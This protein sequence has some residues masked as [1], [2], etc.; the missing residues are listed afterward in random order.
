[1]EM[2]QPRGLD[3]ATATMKTQEQGRNQWR[4]TK[5][6]LPLSTNKRSPP[7]PKKAWKKA[8]A[9]TKST[10]K[11]TGK[12][13]STVSTQTTLRRSKSPPSSFLQILM[14]TPRD[15]PGHENMTIMGK[16]MEAMMGIMGEFKSLLETTKN[17]QLP[18][19]DTADAVTTQVG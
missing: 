16:L 14:V 3:W 4:A 12:V 9:S 6:Q 7:K 5:F 17:Y 13:P 1:M 10:I 15:E 2:A 8:T 11:K 19:P 18:A